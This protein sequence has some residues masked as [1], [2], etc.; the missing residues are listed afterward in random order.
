MTQWK[1]TIQQQ[2]TNMDKKMSFFFLDAGRIRNEPVW[3]KLCCS[4]FFLSEKHDFV[5]FFANIFWLYS[6]NKDIEEKKWM[7]DSLEN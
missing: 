4:R 7:T 6:P 1:K 5:L 2:L 3:I